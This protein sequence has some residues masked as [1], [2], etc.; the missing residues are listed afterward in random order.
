MSDL[1]EL[2]EN[3]QIKKTVT[4]TE[5]GEDHSREITLQE[6][7]ART[8]TQIIGTMSGAN[9]TAYF[10][11]AIGLILDNNVI[12]NPKL[13]FH[14]L[15]HNLSKEDAK[16]SVELVNG[17]GKKVTLYMKF[18]DYRTAFN[19]LM[20]AQKTDGSVD[21]TGMLD[22]LF[23]NVLVDGNQ[24]KLDWDWLDDHNKGYGLTSDVMQEAIKFLSDVLNKDGVFSML[25]EG[26]Q[27]ATRQISRVR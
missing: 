9:N 16:S 25:M 27:L 22:L 4:W 26:F 20:Y 6:P 15:N 5:D 10:G 13:S 11:E 21:I 1:Q 12:V 19:I 7:D 14:D 24:K 18:P 23:E 2:L 3:H 17:D 8:A